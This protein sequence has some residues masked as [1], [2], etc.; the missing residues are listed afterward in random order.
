MLNIVP[1]LQ[2]RPGVAAGM[3]PLTV[4]S[5]T[6][7]SGE[8]FK[9]VNRLSSSVSVVLFSVCL[10][11]HYGP[12]CFSADW[13]VW[14]TLGYN[15][16]VLTCSLKKALSTGIRLSWQGQL[17]LALPISRNVSIKLL[18]VFWFPYCLVSSV[19][20]IYP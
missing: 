18:S 20:Y 13:P 9:A 2:P 7:C 17:S 12:A 5:G 10:R 3:Q 16:L 8:P 14:E 15:L 19:N 1:I 6:K 4:W 11:T